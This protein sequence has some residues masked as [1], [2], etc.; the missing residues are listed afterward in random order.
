MEIFTILIKI[1]WFVVIIIAQFFWFVF[2]LVPLW[3]FLTLIEKLMIWWNQIVKLMLENVMWRIFLVLFVFFVWYLITVW[4]L[5]LIVNVNIFKK[6]IDKHNEWVKQK[7]YELTFEVVNTF[8]QNFINAI[9]AVQSKNKWEHILSTLEWIK[10]NIFIKFLFFQWWIWK[11]RHIKSVF[12]WLTEK[13]VWFNLFLIIAIIIWSWYVLSYEKEYTWWNW[14]VVYVSNWYEYLKDSIAKHDVIWKFTQTLTNWVNESITYRDRRIQMIVKLYYHSSFMKWLWWVDL[15][16]TQEKYINF[17]WWEWWDNQVSSFDDLKNNEG[18]NVKLNNNQWIAQYI[19]KSIWTQYVKDSVSELWYKWI[20]FDEFMNSLFW[21]SASKFVK[22]SEMKSCLSQINSNKQLKEKYFIDESLYNSRI[23][24]QYLSWKLNWW[25][26]KKWISDFELTLDKIKN[27]KNWNYIHESLINWLLKKYNFSIP[28]RWWSWNAIWLYFILWKDWDYYL[29][30]KWLYQDFINKYS[31][32]TYHVWTTYLNPELQYRANSKI[33]DF[34]YWYSLLSQYKIQWWLWEKNWQYWNISYKEY[35]YEKILEKLYISIW[36]KIKNDQLS[37]KDVLQLSWYLLTNTEFYLRD[38]FNQWKDFDNLWNY[39]YMFQNNK[40]KTSYEYLIW[41]TMSWL[42]SNLNSF[43]ESLKYQTF[44]KTKS[45]EE[46]MKNSKTQDI[47]WKYTSI[48]KSFALYQQKIIS[49]IKSKYDV[50]PSTKIFNDTS[51][52]R[53]ESMYFNWYK[54][55]NLN[56]WWEILWNAEISNLLIWINSK[57]DIN[58]IEN[59][60]DDS[61]KQDVLYFWKEL[62]LSKTLWEWTQYKKVWVM[63]WLI[64]IIESNLWFMNYILAICYWVIYIV[65]IF[66]MFWFSWIWQIFRNYA[67][68]KNWNTDQQ[69]FNYIQEVTDLIVRLV[70]FLFLMKLYFIF[71]V[72]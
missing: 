16:S 65:F 41:W 27:R 1:F 10:N 4:L 31:N 49:T 5:H 62:T 3:L 7:K 40:K 44:D 8:R 50:L 28:W 34:C 23:F 58:E 13:W 52:E 17:W 25:S 32:W 2:K 60:T 12:E 71:T 30:D 59:I 35:D 54:Q 64:P 46:N 57:I 55:E 63:M 69:E 29:I 43:I 24:N 36:S 45:V 56:F 38:S 47:V 72:F 42:Y 70:I 37:D 33:S 61:T 15:I 21:T 6:A 14:E 39:F 26:T 53:L 48:K 19:W 68:F 11:N 20:Y 9:K 67:E 66:L 22:W 18:W 51:L